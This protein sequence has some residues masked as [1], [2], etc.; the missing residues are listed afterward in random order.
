MCIFSLCE[1]R[2]AAASCTAVETRPPVMPPH[3]PTH[4]F[5]ASF[6][7]V[8]LRSSSSSVRSCLATSFYM[9]ALSVVFIRLKAQKNACANWVYETKQLEASQTKNNHNNYNT[10]KLLTYV[11]RCWIVVARIIPQHHPHARVQSKTSI[12]SFAPNVKIITILTLFHQVGI[13]ST[14]GEGFGHFGGSWCEKHFALSWVEIVKWTYLP[15]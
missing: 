8:K 3:S 9:L 15:T 2:S 14:I 1:Y 12:I 11:E 6:L 7:V 4:F 5:S 13:E 10:N